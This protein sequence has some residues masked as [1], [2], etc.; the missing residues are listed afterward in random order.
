[1][2]FFCVGD[3]VSQAAQSFLPSVI[4]RP[5]AAQ[6]LGR[7]LMTTGVLVGIVNCAAAG[8][9]TSLRACQSDPMLETVVG[10]EWGLRS[11]CASHAVRESATESLANFAR[12]AVQAAWWSQR[13]G[14]SPTAARW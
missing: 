8:A 10:D 14:C 12:C 7:Q 6:R 3:A 2:F 4:G 5:S 9:T 11:R 1:M 13:R